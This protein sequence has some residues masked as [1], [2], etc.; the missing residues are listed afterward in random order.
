MNNPFKNF[1]NKKNKSEVVIQNHHEE[2]QD[3]VEVF[4][5]DYGNDLEYGIDGEPLVYNYRENADEISELKRTVELMQ[6]SIKCYEN[7]YLKLKTLYQKSK[8]EYSK[9][10]SKYNILNE[11][12]EYTI[13]QVSDARELIKTDPEYIKELNKMGLVLNEQ[14][15]DILKEFKAMSIKYHEMREDYDYLQKKLNKV[16][17]DRIL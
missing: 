9:L 8:L 10:E 6:N 5:N 17:A 7:K 1:L 2:T 12:Y 13:N 3:E 15:D 14:Y 16:F 4:D 11:D